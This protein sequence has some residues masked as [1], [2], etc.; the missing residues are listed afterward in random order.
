MRS[1]IYLTKKIFPS[2]IIC[3]GRNYAEHAKELNNPVPNEAVIFISPNSAISQDIICNEMDE[4]YYEGDITFLLMGEKIN[5]I[6]FGRN[7]TKISFVVLDTS[8]HF[9]FDS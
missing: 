8:P 3:I 4:I 2:K 6:G 7:S 9:S 5:S 1:V